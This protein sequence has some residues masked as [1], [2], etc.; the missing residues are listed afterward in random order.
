[1][2]IARLGPP[3]RTS[4]RAF[5][6]SGMI[7]VRLWPP[8]LSG[9]IGATHWNAFQRDVTLARLPGRGTPSAPVLF[10]FFGYTGCFETRP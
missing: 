10:R 9:G 5:T 2:G 6:L 1:M 7:A 3:V 8:C 4:I